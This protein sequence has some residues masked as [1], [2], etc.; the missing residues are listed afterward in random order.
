MARTLRRKTKD[1][2]DGG[3]VE[4]AGEMTVAANNGE[5][6]PQI[7]ELQNLMDF[8][9]NKVEA[10]KASYS[11]QNTQLARANS[12]LMVKLSEIENKISE[13]VQEN[14][15]LRSKVSI[16][17]MNYKRRLSEQLDVLESG[18]S[19]RVE[20]IFLMFDSVRAKEGLTCSDKSGQ[21]RSIL[22]K[23]RSLGSS[24]G[25]NK[26]ANSIQFLDAA[27]QVIGAPELEAS[28]S[29]GDSAA[30][31]EE[32]AARR[33]RRKSSRRESIFLPE[34]FELP[35][36]EPVSNPSEGGV[37]EENGENDHGGMEL[38]S[39]IDGLNEQEAGQA[40]LQPTNDIELPSE[41]NEQNAHADGSFS[42]TN[43]IIDYSIPEETAPSATTNTEQSS[44][45]KI[46]VF[47][48]EPESKSS[49]QNGEDRKE[50]T[51]VPLSSQS[52]AKHSR[53]APTAR[54]RKSM[55]D[56]VMPTTN[57]GNAACDI[58]FTRIRRTRGKAIDYKLPSLRAKMRRPT[59]KLVDATTFTNIHE[60]QVTN[61]R[62][63]YK[64]SSN[65]KGASATTAA[66]LK[67]TVIA[68]DAWH[69]DARDQSRK[70]KEAGKLEQEHNCN[71][72][73]SKG[74]LPER[75]GVQREKATTECQPILKDI[76]NRPK[77][78]K[79]RKLLK[80][81]IINDICDNNVG[82]SDDTT[83]SLGSNGSSFRLN[84][85]DLSVFD[86]IGS[87]KAKPTNKTYRAKS[88]KL[89]T[90]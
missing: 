80:S 20:E 86:L 8:Q 17:E 72:P 78:S 90:K 73:S 36:Q 29:N 79:T 66:A 74:P 75:V 6:I 27:N 28:A 49:S 21:L 57:N 81:A 68:G 69:K 33:K 46:E 11:Q 31:Q 58:E 48:D 77:I 71:Q 70:D 60:L 15:T 44:S 42:F 65:R 64:K 55:V 16:G 88:R 76:T 82:M 41:H 9:K 53:R 62:R 40:I 22:R 1:N 34:D 23:R 7:Q 84:E 47:R 14:V 4:G 18:I 52:K 35:S 3:K 59:E 26:S 51:F 39:I 50:Q 87:D 12:S 32:N 83:D 89:I 56:E 54:S 19:H 37:D 38:L 10:I 30:N 85:E 2:G 43:S 13:L 25:D 5:S 63:S 24:Q 45:S 67:E 61:A